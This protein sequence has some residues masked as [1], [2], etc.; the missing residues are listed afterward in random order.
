VNDIIGRLQRADSIS[1]VTETREDIRILQVQGEKKEHLSV[2]LPKGHQSCLFYDDTPQICCSS[3]LSCNQL[4]WLFVLSDTCWFLI[5]TQ[6]ETTI[7]YYT[8]SQHNL[9][10]DLIRKCLATTY[11]KPH[12]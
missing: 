10:H 6:F 12:I 11:I 9:C 7:N 5:C 1:M 8:S 4:Y 3:F 2:A